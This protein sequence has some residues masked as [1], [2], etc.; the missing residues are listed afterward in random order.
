MIFQETFGELGQLVARETEDHFSSPLEKQGRGGKLAE[1][2]PSV[3]QK[4]S[5]FG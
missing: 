4:A 3:F 1:S 2:S 5:R